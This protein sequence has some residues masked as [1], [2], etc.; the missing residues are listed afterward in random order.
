V[1]DAPARPPTPA[2]LV[3]SPGGLSH[4]STAASVTSAFARFETEEELLAFMAANSQAYT[5]PTAAAPPPATRVTTTSAR[6]GKAAAES[7][8]GV[9][10][11]SAF[12][13]FET[14]E[15]LLAF[16]AANSQAYTTPTFTAPTTGTH[17]SVL[18]RSSKT[19]RSVR[20]STY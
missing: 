3:D 20:R 14:E 9:S 17:P 8:G 7:I 4:A 10:A 1:P 19:A 11:T 16:M 5:T 13:R 18:A 15:E 2:S 12:A 6:P